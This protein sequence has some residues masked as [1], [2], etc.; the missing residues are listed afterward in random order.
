MKP[1]QKKKDFFY[2]K[3]KKEKYRARS[4]YKLIELNKKYRLIKQGDFVID[5]GASPGS[6][7]QVALE[8]VGRDGFV[9]AVDILPMVPL[10]GSF[11]FLRAD[12]S[13]PNILDK[14]KKNFPGNADVI[15]SDAAPEF[16]GIRSRDVGL[17]LRLNQDILKISKEILKPRGILVFKTFQ[18]SE[19]SEL[20]SEIKTI[21]KT[22]K[23]VKPKAS[24]RKSPEIYVVAKNKI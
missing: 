24:L 14:I 5:I 21:F 11:G 3:A 22:T 8:L 15:I 9:L 6:W 16:S 20:V 23:I 18:N 10:D 4:A 12:I 1:Q 13:K 7:S 2:K 19:L 17:T